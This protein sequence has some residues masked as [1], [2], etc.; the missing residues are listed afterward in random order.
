MSDSNET[1]GRQRQIHFSF[2]FFPP[3]SVDAEASWWRSVEELSAY[4]PGFVS[5]TYGAGATSQTPTYAAV[6]RLVDETRLATASHL[7]VVKASKGEVDDVIRR[8]RDAGIRRFV[9]LRGDPPGGI[10]TAYSPHPGGYANAAALVSALKAIDQDFDI[11][12]SAYPEKH[13]ESAD[14]TADIAML[15]AKA[16]NGADRAL[17]QFFFDN[18]VFEDYLNEVRRAGI[19][20]PVVPGIM[21]IQ[22]LAQLKRFAAMCGASVPAFVERRFEGLDDDPEGRFEAAADL[23]AEQVQ[24]LVARGVGD[25]HFYTM[26]KSKLMAAVLDRLGIRPGRALADAVPER[27]RA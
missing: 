3:K 8:F 18:D 24:D 4:D 9:A 14:R 17:T 1:R 27:L 5:V 6:K 10:G 19:T 25:F 20:I 16:D 26:N 11:S 12:V 23:A 13:P 15:K 2:E 21:P 7:T 22:N